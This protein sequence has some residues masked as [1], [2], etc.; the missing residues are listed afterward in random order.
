MN[1][2]ETAI[3][4]VVIIE[5]RFYWFLTRFECQVTTHLYEYVS[6]GTIYRLAY[7]TNAKTAS[8]REYWFFFAV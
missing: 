5:P 6:K 1:I 8:Q 3:K 2:I 7:R 4:G